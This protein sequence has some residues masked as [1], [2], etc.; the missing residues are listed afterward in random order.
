MAETTSCVN[1]SGTGV[2]IGSLGVL[3]GGIEPISSPAI[4]SEQPSLAVYD[5]HVANGHVPY[6]S[7]AGSARPLG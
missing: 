6:R 1:V 5:E 2:S 4:A 3:T 7:I